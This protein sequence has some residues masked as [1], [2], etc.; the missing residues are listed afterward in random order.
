MG[1]SQRSRFDGPLSIIAGLAIVS[2]II[3][4]PGILFL[5]QMFMS[6]LLG[7][8][9]QPAYVER[10]RMTINVVV[11]GRERSGTSVNEFVYRPTPKWF[12][13]FGPPP[14]EGMIVGQALCIDLGK[15]GALVLTFGDR[16]QASPSEVLRYP[17]AQIGVPNPVPGLPALPAESSAN[18]Q[19]FLL[20][21]HDLWSMEYFSDP[22]DSRSRAAVDPADLSPVLGTDAR[23]TFVALR[24]S[25]AAMTKG[26]ESC[27]PFI[28]NLHPSKLTDFVR[29]L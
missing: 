17:I 16:G 26:L 14:R 5:G 1:P 21:S 24:P 10:F 29:G 19:Q 28:K 2:L 6:D 8:W 20:S 12:V 18:S 15:R 3:V 9:L 25:S 27:V 7:D 22:T 13:T 4:I 23:I 11:D